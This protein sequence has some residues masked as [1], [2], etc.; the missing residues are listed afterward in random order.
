[1]SIPT[2][3][4]SI[5]IVEDD[6]DIRAAMAELLENEG[7]EISV[8]SNGQE[9]LEVIEQMPRPCLVLL[10][11]MMPVMSGEDFLRHLRKH[12]VFHSL[13]VIIVTASGRQPLPGAQGILKKP[14]EIGELFATV[15]AHCDG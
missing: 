13:P 4:G 2:S 7:F 10:D 11:L 5:L 12:P 3:R 14:F 9:G 1:M 15:A 6:E 8:A